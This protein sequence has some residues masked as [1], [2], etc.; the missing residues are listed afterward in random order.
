[1]NFIKNKHPMSFKEFSDQLEDLI[2][3]FMLQNAV[4]I[5]DGDGFYWYHIVTLNNREYGIKL[6]SERIG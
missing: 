4:K 1:M 2:H 6:K 3:T 5:E